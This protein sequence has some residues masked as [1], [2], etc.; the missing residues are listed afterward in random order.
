MSK[1][2][3]GGIP[4]HGTELF[5]KSNME[6]EE[7]SQPTSAPTS[8]ATSHS[9]PSQSSGHKTEDFLTSSSYNTGDMQERVG[10]KLK[11]VN[12]DDLQHS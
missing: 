11:V 5:P 10:S 1:V 6:G 12:P 7:T 9:G 2:Y 8:G 3:E 4:D